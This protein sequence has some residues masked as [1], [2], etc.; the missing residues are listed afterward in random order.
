MTAAVLSTQQLREQAAVLADA[1]MEAGLGTKRMFAAK[2]CKV[3]FNSDLDE[4]NSLVL[5]Y[6]EPPHLSTGRGTPHLPTRELRV[7]RRARDGRHHRRAAGLDAQRRRR[8]GGARAQHHQEGRARRVASMKRTPAEDRV[9]RATHEQAAVLADALEDAGLKT[10][11]PSSAGT[12]RG[13]IKK[14]GLGEWL[15]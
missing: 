11:S 3:T 6:G 7:H 9:R 15:R 2:N 8:V 12:V 10:G 4:Y 13:I 1:L 5:R 14:A